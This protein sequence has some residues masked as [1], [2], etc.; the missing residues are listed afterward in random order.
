MTGNKKIFIIAGEAS[1]DLHGSE[2]I[3]EIKK[4]DSKVEIW[5]VGGDKMKEAGA[6]IL[7]PSSRLSVV[8]LTEVLSHA[9]PIV[10][11]F[12]TIRS[13][14]KKGGF[15]LL[16]LI[17][18]PEFNMLMARFAK[19]IGLKVLYYIS[20]QVWAWRQGRV[21]KIRKYVDKL[22]VILPFE[23]DF[24]KRYGLE[25]EYVGHPLIDVVKE[26]EDKEEFVTRVGLKDTETLISL[27]PGSRRSEIKSLLPLMLEVSKKLTNEF[28]KLRFF[29]AIAPN[30]TKETE[31]FIID[32]VNNEKEDG[33][34]ISCLK[35]STYHALSCSRFALLASGTA[36]LE[37]AILNCPMIVLYKLSPITY[38]LGRLLIKVKWVSL[39][40]LIAQKQIVPELLQH[41]ANI[42]KVYEEA[43]RYL[44]DDKLYI[45][46]KK[47]L[48]DL[49]KRLGDGDAAKKTAKIALELIN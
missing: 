13:C 15:N 36:A 3:K 5:A 44:E 48:V 21:K 14:L 25:V 11:S 46:T 27:L 17:D 22:A 37:A 29:V 4:I 8:G 24:Y 9:F 35:N 16:I 31:Q 40:N 12:F 18:F 32:L 19:K 33:L 6:N 45:N 39:V 42:K 49:K 2:L 28:D 10:S 41:D 47:E 7:V 38:F 23:K 30:L 20:P 43:K 26:P 34:K 1:G